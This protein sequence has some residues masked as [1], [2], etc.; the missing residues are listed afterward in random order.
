MILLCLEAFIRPVV[1]RYLVS[2][3]TLVHDVSLFPVFAELILQASKV[4]TIE[5][6]IFLLV[7]DFLKPLL[8]R[9]LQLYILCLLAL[10]VHQVISVTLLVKRV[11]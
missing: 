9:I 6:P 10:L 4:I 2:T 11:E 7:F 5:V 8:P 3:A 1:R